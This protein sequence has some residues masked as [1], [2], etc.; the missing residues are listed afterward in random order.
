VR[1]P[2]ADTFVKLERLLAGA[3]VHEALR[4]LNSRTPHRFT[5]IYRFDGG[6]LRNLHLFD[7]EQA[8]VRCGE[9]APLAETY[10]SIVD[11]FER[12]F[13]TADARNDDRLRTHPAR[14]KVVSYCGV[15]LRDEQGN[16]FGTLCHFDRVACDIPT[17]EIPLMEAAAPLVMRVLKADAD[18]KS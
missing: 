2:R 17:A 5:G 10:C 4:F 11:Q 12:S 14:E 3:D 13:T 1:K 8:D 9:D 18:A 16:A 15:L 7:A 6:I